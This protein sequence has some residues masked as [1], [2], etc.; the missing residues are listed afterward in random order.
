MYRATSDIVD[1]VPCLSFCAARLRFLRFGEGRRWGGL[2]GRAT[3]PCVGQVR[4]ES[5]SSHYENGFRMLRLDVVATG[6]GLVVYTAM[7]C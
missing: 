2:I 6:H 1:G 7:W 4:L 3:N 5:F